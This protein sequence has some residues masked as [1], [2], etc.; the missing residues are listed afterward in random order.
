MSIFSGPVEHEANP[1]ESWEVRPIR[2]R[3][4]LLT[5]DGVR[6]DSFPTRTEAE[7]AKTEGFLADL[8]AKETRWYAGEPVAGWQP[9]GRSQ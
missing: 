9:Y 4:D 5:K 6:L 1:P 7:R 8:Y 2:R 3:W